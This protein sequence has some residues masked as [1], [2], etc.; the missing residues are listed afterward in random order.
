MLFNRT[1]TTEDYV[2]KILSRGSMP[3]PKLVE[4]IKEK[5]KVS[6]QG[7][8]K[9]I[10]K[11]YKEEVV[12]IRDKNIS[13]HLSWV[14]KLS[15]FSKET[16]QNYGGESGKEEFMQ[17]QEGE[18]LTY[19]FKSLL[20]LDIL[21]THVLASFLE[22]RKSDSD[23]LIFN[24]HQWFLLG[25]KDVEEN[26]L[27]KTKEKGIKW[28]QIIGGNT[29]LDKEIIKML[30][31]RE[32]S[33]SLTEKKYFNENTYINVLGDFVIEATLSERAVLGIEKIFSIHKELE[34]AAKE[35]AT[36][37]KENTGI[38]KLKIMRSKRKTL[39]VR[40]IFM[41]HFWIKRA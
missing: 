4:M 8:Y 12:S 7:A 30:S 26:L 15:D 40:K 32:I 18:S 1:S 2:V 33:F 25:R 6:K 36:L 16:L 31:S 41:R 23:L 5:F 37:I 21:W 17:L 24:P 29:D 3:K 34:S 14:T 22:N 35:I 9:A 20:N 13:L 27:R 38:Q 28:L 39:T 19:K 10:R 11:L